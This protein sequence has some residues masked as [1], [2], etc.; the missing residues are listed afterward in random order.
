[1]LL[2][3]FSKLAASTNFN[4]VINEIHVSP[5]FA[6]GESAGEIARLRETAHFQGVIAD[7]PAVFF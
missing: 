3:G 6:D 7:E 1:L 4:E 2:P 5:R